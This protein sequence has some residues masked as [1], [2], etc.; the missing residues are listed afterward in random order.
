MGGL[1]RGIG[2]ECSLTRLIDTV[3]QNEFATDFVQKRFMPPPSPS[4]L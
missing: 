4:E 3:L 1:F 2:Q